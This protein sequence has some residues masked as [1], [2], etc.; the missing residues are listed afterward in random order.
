MLGDEDGCVER[1]GERLG[2]ELGVIVG[3]CV[4]SATVGELDVD[5]GR[6]GLTLAFNDG[7][8]LKLGADE[9]LGIAEGTL[10][11]SQENGGSLLSQTKSSGQSELWRHSQ[12]SS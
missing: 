3:L 10:A 5:G 6:L 7:D 2:D 4:G 11:T 1:E 8:E 12:T 9:V